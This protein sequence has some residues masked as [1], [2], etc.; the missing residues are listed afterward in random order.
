MQFCRIH[1]TIL[2]LLVPLLLAWTQ[3]WSSI[4]NA[5]RSIST[6]QA[7]FVQTKHLK[8]LARPITSE[9][10]IFY[11][12][13]GDIRWEYTT[14]IKSIMVKNKRGI[15]RVT[16]R[17]GEYHSDAEAKLRPVQMVLDQIELW[18]RG[19]FAQS[20]LCGENGLT[21]RILPTSRLERLK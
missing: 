17:A 1:R 4:Q 18:L 16:W 20:P 15:R 5:A 11:R 2:P 8:I 14:P 12:R 9:G 19:D 21:I 6:M 7:E 13:P 10:R 3:S